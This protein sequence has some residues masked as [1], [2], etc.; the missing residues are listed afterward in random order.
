MLPLQQRGVQPAAGWQACC[1]Q[2]QRCRCL[3]QLM[4]V[5]FQLHFQ[6]LLSLLLLATIACGAYSVFLCW[7]CYSLLLCPLSSPLSHLAL[8]LS[9][10]SGR[11]RP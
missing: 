7:L 8:A 9:L 2:D 10:G 6:E 11:L 4:T 1:H 3:L 5:G